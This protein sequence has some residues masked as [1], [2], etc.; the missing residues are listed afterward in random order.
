MAVS[1]QVIIQAPATE[2]IQSIIARIP[3]DPS[4]LIILLGS[5]DPA[6]NPVVQSFW[7][8]ALIPAAVASGSRILDNGIG[9]PEGTT[10]SSLATITGQAVR[11]A[12]QRPALIGITPHSAPVEPNHQIIVS[13]AEDWPDNPVKAMLQFAR[14]LR[15][16]PAGRDK[17]VVVVLAGGGA[18]EKAALVTC[19]RRGWPVLAIEQTGGT[20]DEVLAA[21]KPGTDGQVVIPQDPDLREIIETGD[22]GTLSLTGSID[23]LNRILLAYLDLR[24]DTLADAWNRY[25]AL[26]EAAIGKQRLFRT[27]QKVILGLGVGATFL[28]VVTSGG[29]LSCLKP[30]LLRHGIAPFVPTAKGAAHVLMVITPIAIS[31][32]AAVSSRFREGNKWILLRASAEAMKRELFRY[33]TQTGSY[34]DAQCRLIS[35]EGKLAAELKNI[36]SN[37]AQSEVNRTSLPDPPPPKDAA[38]K[39]AADLKNAARLKF[40]DPDSYFTERIDDQIRY[41][42][43]KTAQLYKQLKSFQ[44]WIYVW[45]GLGTLLAAFGFNVWVALTIAVAALLTT[46]LEMDQVENSLIQ[47]NQALTGLRNITSW[48]RALSQWEQARPANIDLLVEQTERTLAG[49][50]AG[51]VQQM[52]SALDKLTEKEQAQQKGKS[53]Q[54]NT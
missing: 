43:S 23:D 10:S 13:L 53:Q 45:G 36:S 35:R 48:W 9:Q 3:G 51:W 42:V 39:K 38:D 12:E 25:D 11:D 30:F 28:A 7:N 17:P 50:L 44:I 40:I 54:A 52:Q 1:P 29:A 32:L 27:L 26:D 2:E 6:L 34:R 47:Y 15:K 5:V 20:A 24:A 46:R 18:G 16:N 22:T 41:F 49:E 19:A 4:P 14:E 33:R 37:L 21:L 31:V 8:R